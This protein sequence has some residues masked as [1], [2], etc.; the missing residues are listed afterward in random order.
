MKKA[1]FSAF[2]FIMLFIAGVINAVG[3]TLLLAPVNLYDSG[4]SG[5]SML[6]S[7]LTPDWLQLWM[8]LLV[9]NLPIYLFGLKKQGVE[10]TVYSLPMS[11][12]K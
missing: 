9:I 7:W 1:E 4:V 11:F 10:F 2:N 5:L 12:R 6:I 3:V 8:A